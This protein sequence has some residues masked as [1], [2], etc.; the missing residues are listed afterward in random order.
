MAPN[1]F[2]RKKALGILFKRGKINNNQDLKTIL[3][4][5][6]SKPIKLLLALGRR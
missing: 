6:P 1:K 2:A 4:L 3:G 5:Q